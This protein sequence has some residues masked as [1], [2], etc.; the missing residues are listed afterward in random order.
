MA[1]GHGTHTHRC[2]G[3][4]LQGVGESVSLPALQNSGWGVPKR[5]RFGE[6]QLVNA[7]VLGVA[8]GV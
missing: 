8:S 2:R 3:A 5:Q 6:R 4:L 7:D 1:T